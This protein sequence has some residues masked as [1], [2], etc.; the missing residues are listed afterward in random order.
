MAYFTH[1]THNQEA[2]FNRELFYTT[3]DEDRINIL[4]TMP[5]VCVCVC[6]EKIFQ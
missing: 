3:L 1:F 2:D 5:C 4:Q 6:V